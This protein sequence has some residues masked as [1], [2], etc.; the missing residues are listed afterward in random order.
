MRPGAVL[1][2]VVAAI[3]LPRPATAQPAASPNLRGASGLLRIPD[4]LVPAEG[5]LTAFYTDAPDP[6]WRAFGAMNTFALTLGLAPFLEVGARASDQTPVFRIRDLAVHAKLQLPLPRLSRWLPALAVGVDDYGGEG[7]YSRSRYVVA[8]ETV[9]FARLT[10]GYGLGPD[11]L[12]GAFGGLELRPV[13]WLHLLGDHSDR[14]TRLG[15]RVQLP[16]RVGQT[17][18]ALVGLVESTLGA[19]PTDFE[20]GAGVVA[21]LGVSPGEPVPEGLPALP[22]PPLEPF[23]I[24]GGDALVALSDALVARGFDEVLVGAR[25]EGVLVVEL[26]DNRWNSNALDGLGVALG[27]AA[28]HAPANTGWIVLVE[29]RR[30][31]RVRE[32]WAPAAASRAYFERG[33]ARALVEGQL[34]WTTCLSDPSDLRVATP[35]RSRSAGRVQLVLAPS[36][37]TYLATDLA[38]LDFLVGVHPEARLALWRGALVEAALEIPVLWSSGYEDGRY[39]RAD[40]KDAHVEHALLHQAVALAPGVLGL[41]GVGLYGRNKLGT[42]GQVQWTSPDGAHRLRV[43]GAYFR[44]RYDES[45]ASALGSYRLWLAS[46]DLSLEVTLGRYFRGD[47]GVELEVARLFGDTE[48]GLFFRRTLVDIAGI[49]FTFPLTPRRD[50]RPA[51]AQLRGDPRFRYRQISTVNRLNTFFPGLGWIPETSVNLSDAFSNAGRTGTATL[52]AHLPRLREAYL[53]YRDD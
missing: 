1:I 6:R 15:A 27:L 35:R 17:P 19:H 50:M 48:V 39:F 52:L 36:I 12:D 7:L 40:R 20:L 51:F 28:R 33:E 44:D 5:T 25:G 24:A 3:G 11:R 16:L 34:E 21:A 22:G 32:L 8:T 14:Q 31:L 30:G 41:A 47:Q 38:M 45:F 4:A 43:R 2:V 49:Q 46:L 29:L 18:L 13:P 10:A 42:L 23:E 53:R 37:A 26:E 9:A